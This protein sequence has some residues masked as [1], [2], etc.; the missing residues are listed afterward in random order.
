[1]RVQGL[2]L[3]P[4]V[5]DRE[6]LYAYSTA[7]VHCSLHSR[8]TRV[9]FS[10]NDPFWFCLLS[11]RKLTPFNIFSIAVHSQPFEVFVLF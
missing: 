5:C 4:V 9:L 6:K 10:E 1:M 11:D 7:C 8:N 2:C 3:M